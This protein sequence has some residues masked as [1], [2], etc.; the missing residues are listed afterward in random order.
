MEVRV[1][2]DLPA[3]PA[4]PIT[5]G[6]GLRWVSSLRG[7]DELEI[8]HRVDACFVQYSGLLVIGTGFAETAEGVANVLHPKKS[9]DELWD[10]QRLLGV[11][12]SP[13]VM[14]VNYDGNELP[15]LAL[16][17]EDLEGVD[18]FIDFI[19]SN[20]TRG[21]CTTR[22]SFVLR[23]MRDGKSVLEE[24]FVVGTCPGWRD[25]VAPWELVMRAKGINLRAKRS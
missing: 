17:R 14:T 15:P 6:A 11:V 18:R 24:E 8:H 25:V 21:G 2:A 4:E 16:T 19:R 3:V 13:A 23:W 9:D 20:E 5:G 7:D 1:V 12:L 10:V 22:E